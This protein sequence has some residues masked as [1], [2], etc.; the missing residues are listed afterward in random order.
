MS[1]FHAGPAPKGLGPRPGA[2]RDGLGLQAG[3]KVGLFGGSFN[4]AHDGHAHVAETAMRRLDLD[5]VVWLVSPQNPLKSDQETAPLE[6]RMTS[7]RGVAATVGPA[8]IVSDFET[9]AGTQWTVDTLRMLKARYPGVQF[10]WL[11]GSDNLASFHRWRGWTDIMHLMP[12]AVIARPGS[13]LDSRTA[14]A[15]SRYARFRIPAP[16]AGLLPSLQAPAWTY[17]TAPLNPRSSSAI[18][19]GEGLIPGGG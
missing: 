16:R 5:R 4:P 3:M 14:P 2:L 18:R 11:M 10:V 9:R 15:A 8:M 7:A 13:Q 6:A 17:L 12:V 19:R 1:F